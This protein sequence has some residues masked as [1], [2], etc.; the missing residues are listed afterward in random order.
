LE[1]HFKFR[2]FL[3]PDIDVVV[4]AQEAGL[5]IAVRSN[6]EAVAE[7]AELCIVARADNFNLSAIQAVFFPVVHPPGDDLF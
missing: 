5:E 6:P 1:Q 7:C 3:S 4:G 2:T